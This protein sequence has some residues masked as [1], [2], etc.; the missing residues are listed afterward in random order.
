MNACFRPVAG[1]SGW[2]RLTCGA[3]AKADKQIDLKYLGWVG[4]ACCHCACCN[5]P[6]FLHQGLTSATGVSAAAVET[7]PAAACGWVS[8]VFSGAGAST[9]TL[10]PIN[11]VIM[12]G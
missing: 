11:T 2:P 8:L 5:H 3:Q 1:Q 7:I 9:V 12:V 4:G 10:P 6:V